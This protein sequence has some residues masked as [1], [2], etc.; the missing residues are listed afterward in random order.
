MVNKIYDYDCD[1]GYNNDNG[2]KGRQSENLFGGE[3]HRVFEGVRH[4]TDHPVTNTETPASNHKGALWLDQRTKILYMWVGHGYKSDRVRN[5]WLPVFNDK[6][7]IFDEM[8][9]DM[10]TS[11]PV[12]GQLWLYDGILMYYDGTNWIPVKTLEAIDSQ[13]NIST[14]ED[15]RIYAPLNRMGSA[16]I[17]DIELEAH[18]A[19][20][21]RYFN[22]D[23]DIKGGDNV[24]VK[25]RYRFGDEFVGQYTNIN[26]DLSEVSYQYLVPSEK[27]DRIFI[28]G[29]LDKNYLRQNNAVIQYKRS[30]L[31]DEKDRWDDNTPLIAHVKKPVLIHLNPGKLTAIKKRVFKIDKINPKIKC[32]ATNTEFYGYKTGN[33][34][35][36]LLIPCRDIFADKYEYQKLMSALKDDEKDAFVQEL[37][38]QGYNIDSL[39]G[40][41]LSKIAGDY[42]IQDD[43]IYLSEQAA[44]EYDYAV[45]VT[46]EFSWINST[47]ILRQTNS[48]TSNTAFYVPQRLGDMN[49]FVN[50]FDYE[51][52][53]WNWDPENKMVTIAEDV[54]DS[55]K[56]D[57]SVL[58][59]IAHEYGYIR[60]SNIV[61]DNI[62][63]ENVVKSG[64][65]AAQGTKDAYISTIHSF[66]KPLIFVNGIA[67]L[68][69]GYGWEYYNR[70]TLTKTDH[71]TN[72][73]RLK[74]V[75]KDMCWTIIEMA[76]T[77]KKYLSNGV[78]A[79]AEY[80]DICIEDKGILPS[81]SNECPT[82][83]YGNIG[84]SLPLVW[85][86]QG[87]KERKISLEYIDGETFYRL[88]HVI[89][90]VNG[91]MVKRDDLRYDPENEILTCEGLEA[92]MTYIIL[93]DSRNQLY[94]DTMENGIMQALPIGQIDQSLVYHNGYLLNESG[95]Y[96]FG[97]DRDLA[98]LSACHG[99]IRAF[100]GGTTWKVF[101][102]E[103]ADPALSIL[104]TW[105][106]VPDKLPEEVRSFSN[107]YT[108]GNMAITLNGDKVVNNDNNVI[109][110]YGYNFANFVQ[111]PISPITC[112][113][114]DNSKGAA[115]LKGLKNSDEYIK[116]IEDK[117]EEG[118]SLNVLDPADPN[119]VKTQ[120]E[121]LKAYYDFVQG[122]YV[123]WVTDSKISS[124]LTTAQK[125]SKYLEDS[126]REKSAYNS[127]TGYFVSG[128]YVRD[129]AEETEY[130]SKSDLAFGVPW[131]QKIFIGADFDPTTDYVMVWFNG[132]RQYPEHNY[133]IQ[134]VY[135]DDVLKG[136]EIVLGKPSTT[137]VEPSIDKDGYV[138]TPR[139]KGNTV[140]EEFDKELVTGILTYI[141][142]RADRNAT[143][144]CRYCILTADDML[145]G[146]QNVYSTKVLD[147]AHIDPITFERDTSEDFALYPGKVTVYADGLRLPSE[148]YT[149]LDNYTIVIN[150]NIPWVGGN[151]YPKESY[152]DRYGEV[153]SFR[154]LKPEE[155]LVEVRTDSS[156]TD[157]TLYMNR[158]TQGNFD[159]YAVDSGLPGSIVSTQDTI[160][161]FIDGL[162]HG[163]SLNNGYVLN[164]SSGVISVRDSSV[165]EAM[166]KDGLETYLDS[167][168]L[169]NPS[170]ESKFTE[171]L[172]AY[173]ARRD[174]KKHQ[175]TLEWR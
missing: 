170:L 94:T 55:D 98:A 21:K 76:Y 28:D 171:E 104:G 54:S 39:L 127:V 27:N 16:V 15:F 97:E 156:W 1:C 67:L 24:A 10:P 101:N 87:G 29:K 140:P 144:A 123:K 36:T 121:R 120:E 80:I 154:H 108:N 59:V 74:G 143:Q 35:G 52:S 148:A 151:T 91:L 66:N 96:L 149:V 65:G 22:G 70:A 131:V 105:D 78:L 153:K 84:I 145:P 88:P 169:S 77:D 167:I 90:F 125:I 92:G 75:R 142:E 26:F 2:Y 117:L 72:T 158:T 128:V 63:T 11:T 7:Q 48:Q 139:G 110:I 102:T 58:G 155:L 129:A 162:Y 137:G 68:G 160:L 33:I 147:E 51:D 109:T 18:L 95:S 159:I 119:S 132:V 135:E 42:E 106:D 47:G 19:L 138:K 53:L 133:T 141:I 111:N 9:N 85:S 61:D 8:L 157:R 43:G 17:N 112:W 175:I 41:D 124:S 161:I 62:L 166:R 152:I 172:A 69:Q 3:L 89:L 23:T 13:F 44:S 146:A 100:D 20:Q 5:G 122:Q 57:V 46:Y 173:R 82:D 163:L 56:Y 116:L 136:Y 30:Y 38:K 40:Q 150:E 103:S 32:S 86:N 4:L 115:Y 14:F 25:D 31:I 134:P 164:R 81:D 60:Q 73:Y 6:F 107:S 113:I 64:Y 79:S 34:D 12:K 49:I 130:V 174:K 126:K 114:H 168:K 71:R 37:K 118:L 50:G 165:I 83:K 99:E 93:D 45:S